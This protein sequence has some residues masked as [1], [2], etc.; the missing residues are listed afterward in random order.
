MQQ[1]EGHQNY[2]SMSVDGLKHLTKNVSTISITLSAS[3]RPSKLQ[4]R[5]EFDAL[6]IQKI[7]KRRSSIKKIHL[8]LKKIHN[9]TAIC[10]RP[11]LG[12][13]CHKCEPLLP[14]QC[15]IRK[16]KVNH[17]GEEYCIKSNDITNISCHSRC[18]N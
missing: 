5:E 11:K 8:P 10:R 18:V 9:K 6:E 4:I 13:I 14:L 16:F 3:C 12:T 7:K 2:V 1:D 17:T 15:K